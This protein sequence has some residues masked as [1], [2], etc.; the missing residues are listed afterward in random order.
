[1]GFV[2]V[3]NLSPSTLLSPRSHSSSTDRSFALRR[4]LRPYLSNLAHS[5]YAVLRSDGFADDSAA[6]PS[7]HA[8]PFIPLYP[9]ARDGRVSVVHVPNAPATRVPSLVACAR[10]LVL[11][12]QHKRYGT[13]GAEGYEVCEV[14]T[15]DE[16]R[17]MG[18]YRD[19]VV[20]MSADGAGVHGRRR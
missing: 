11:L 16:P 13:D 19:G 6:S 18:V 5:R 2:T 7:G 8:R 15:Y 4:S 9:L 14:S 10:W 1:M 12:L 17:G 3:P 20:V